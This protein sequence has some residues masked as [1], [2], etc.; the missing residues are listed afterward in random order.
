MNPPTTTALVEPAPGAS[1][2]LQSLGAALPWLLSFGLVGFVLTTQDL[3]GLWA[4]LSGANY[5]LFGAAL[6]SFLFVG[7]LLD[8]TSFYLC[9]KWLARVGRFG[10]MLRARAAS[11]LLMLLSLVV[12]LGGL[13]V[14]VHRRYGVSYKRASGI[15]LVD[16]LHEAAAIGTLALLAGLL[17]DPSALP[18]SAA[19][20]LT[21]VHRVAVGTM[22][23]YGVCVFLSLTW[24]YL[25]DAFKRD[26][27]LKVFSE[28]RAQWFAAFYVLKVVKNLAMGLFV[29]VGI[30]AFGVKLPVLVGIAFTQVVLLVRGLPVTAFGI[31]VDQLTIPSLFGPWDPAGEPGQVLAFSAV[32][33]CS[34]LLGRLALGLP[35]L[36]SV[37]RDARS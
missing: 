19:D 9:F 13:A 27:P 36:K 16:L 8:S 14:Y 32:Y 34:L 15:L 25:P 24:K 6:V 5:P 17:V 18:A 28:I 21:A 33:T 26:T 10:E 4:A 37:L 11:E 7:L 12:G 20:E 30:S 23:F 31:G 22:V 2:K 29:A 35:F 1:S 3:T